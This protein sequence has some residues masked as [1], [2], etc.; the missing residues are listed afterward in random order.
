ME[1]GLLVLFLGLSFLLPTLGHFS[2][3]ALGRRDCIIR[4]YQ[5]RGLI[6]SIIVE[7]QYGSHA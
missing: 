1:E 6:L 3:D 7:C 2:A 4:L 5:A